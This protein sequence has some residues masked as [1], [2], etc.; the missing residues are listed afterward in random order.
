MDQVYTTPPRV[1]GAQRTALIIGGIGVALCA[2]GFSA[3]R[4]Q[5]FRSY[6]MAYV[7]WVGVA[8]GSLAV[9]MI[10]HLSGG[11]WAVVIRRVLEASSR[12][13]PF[14]AILFL[15]IV[16]G[17]HELYIWSDPAMV[18][19][20]EVLQ[21][22]APYLNVPFFVLRAALY[23]VIWSSMAF[24]LSKWSL[25]QERGERGQA[26]KMQRLSGGGLVV[27]A[28]TV[29]FMSVDWIMSL[30]PHWYSTIY[31]ILFMGSQGLSALA[32]TI[33]AVVLLGRSEPM[34]RIVA[35]AHL[36]D[37][38]KL[39]LAFVMLWAYFSFSQFLI[40]WSANLPEEV[41]W[42]LRR[43]GGGWQYVGLGLIFLH[44]LLPF[45]L[46]LSRDLKRHGRTLMGVAIVI[47]LARFI[48]LFW[49]IGP[50][51]HGSAEG[52]Y[53]GAPAM[54]HL[55][56]MDAVVPIALGGIWVALF[57]W[58][59]QTRALLPLGEPYLAEA[60]EHGRHGH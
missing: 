19:K 51:E 58:Q 10:G 34:S 57:L 53:A 12:T 56:W 16:F 25:D 36:H 39:L 15:P 23:F 5:F 13:L 21:A 42:Y 52:A 8:L 17:V 60:L 35:P 33:A 38:G 48:D 49:Q 47:I 2:V 18:A 26:L 30:D 24:L 11:A 9:A 59:L 44:F 14:M 32:F 1:A 3:S 45:V 20:D 22:K 28:L 43:M 37:V 46:L 29:L 4:E 27:Y 7:F 55:H 40:I 31:G 41:P 6:L 54:L 50:P